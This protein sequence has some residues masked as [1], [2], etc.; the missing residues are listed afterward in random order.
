VYT[1]QQLHT[2]I[3][4]METSL[5]EL[6]S[7]NEELQSTNEELQS[8]NEE[9]LTTKEEMQ[10]L[11]EELMTINVQYQAKADELTQ[12]NNDMKNLLDSTEIGTI[13]LDN[14]LDILR[15]TPQVRKLFNLIPTDVGRSITH[16]VTNINYPQLEEEIREVI[17]RLTTKELEVQTKTGEWYNVRIMPYRTLDNFIS[18]AVLTFSL[19]TSY[20]LLQFKLNAL[21]QYSADVVN[22][23]REPALQLDS[24]R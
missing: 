19:I 13:F 12:L 5:E 2:T 23:M 7:T 20:K 15:F 6:K 11:N 4:Q 3:E 21:Q 18:G 22:A 16:I 14:K 8:T 24:Y 17:E 9:S 10:S 1:K